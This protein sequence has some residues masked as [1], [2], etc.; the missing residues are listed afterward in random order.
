MLPVERVGCR[1]VFGDAG[2]RWLERVREQLTS[3]GERMFWA[4]E[5]STLRTTDEAEQDRG[6]DTELL[7]GEVADLQL[8]R[9]ASRY[10]RV[11]KPISDRVLAFVML[12]VLLPMLAVV[13]LCVRLQ[14][15]PGVIYRQYRIGLGG[16]PFQMLKFRT[17]DTDRRRETEGA[18]RP[19]R[20][21][22]RDRRHGQAAVVALERRKEH[23]R[24]QL[25]SGRR[26]T[27][28]SSDDPRHTG[29]GRFLRASSIDELPQLVNVLRGDLSLVGPRPELPEVVERYEPWQHARHRVKPGITGLWQVTERADDTPM[30]THVDTDLQY[31]ETLSASTDVR[32]LLLTLPVLLGLRS[33]GRGT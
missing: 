16:T 8:R 9:P 27:H 22:K 21:R 19:D 3:W 5:E 2:N 4:D 14:L 13:A 23:D 25:S 17:M 7:S 6:S 30:H 20:R 12:V 10:E 11:A 18:T 31:V 15:G 32:I 1:T 26:Q 28:K 33:G 29:L 24:R